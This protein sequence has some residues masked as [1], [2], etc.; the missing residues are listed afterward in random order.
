MVIEKL[1]NRGVMTA[2]SL[3]SNNTVKETEN[4]TGIFNESNEEKEKSFR[5]MYSQE[6][7]SKKQQVYGTYR[8]FNE[9]EDERQK[10][11]HQMMRTPGR[12]GEIIKDEE[13]NKEI[14]RR[15]NENQM[16]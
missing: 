4:K 7:M 8:G 1:F 13:I 12:R 15:Y 14:S 3:H 2:D 9:L 11:R 6:L 5:L 10:V 16:E